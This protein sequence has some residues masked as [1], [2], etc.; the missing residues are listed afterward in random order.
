MRSRISGNPGEEQ[1]LAVQRKESLKKGSEK[2]PEPNF[3]LSGITLSSPSGPCLL[4][5]PDLS[6]VKDVEQQDL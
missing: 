1:T 2:I 6:M 5:H 4:P 3:I